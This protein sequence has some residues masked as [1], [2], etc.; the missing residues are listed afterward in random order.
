MENK[1][2]WT[3]KGIGFAF[4]ILGIVWSLSI[5]FFCRSLCEA[6][7]QTQLMMCNYLSLFVGVIIILSGVSLIKYL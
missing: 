3:V 6:G 4:V 5:R 7:S 2:D 1:L